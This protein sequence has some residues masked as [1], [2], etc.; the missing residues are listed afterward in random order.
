[1]LKGGREAFD[2]FTG[3]I[4]DNKGKVQIPAGRIGTKEELLGPA[5]SYYVDNIAGDVPK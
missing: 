2:P 5:M 4:T 3:P 1:M